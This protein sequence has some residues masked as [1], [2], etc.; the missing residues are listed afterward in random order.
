MGNN[1]PNM[2]KGYTDGSVYFGQ[3][4]GEMEQGWGFTDYGY[5]S[6]IKRHEGTPQFTPKLF[7]KIRGI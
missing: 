1:P 4:D 5:N 3:L 2:Q 7:N 6:T